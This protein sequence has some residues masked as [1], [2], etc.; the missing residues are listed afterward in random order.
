MT[1]TF[2]QPVFRYYGVFDATGKAQGFFNDDIYPAQADGTRNPAIPAAAVEISEADWKLLL[3]DQV[4]ARYVNGAVTHVAPPPPPPP[5]ENPTL[6]EAQRANAR[7]DAG[8]SAAVDVA[9]TVRD[10]LQAIPDNFS[11]AHFTAMKIQLDALTEG[12]FRCAAQAGPP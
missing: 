12:S 6:V 3:A 9:V 1:D 7:L 2:T 8:V 4:T 5:P 11:N 10:A